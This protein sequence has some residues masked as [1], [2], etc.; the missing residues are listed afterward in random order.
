MTQPEDNALPDRTVWLKEAQESFDAR[1]WAKALE[2]LSKANECGK[3]NSGELEWL[4]DCARWSGRTDLVVDPLEQA[5]RIYASSK[6]CYGAART[7]LGLCHAY[8]DACQEDLAAAWWQRASELLEGLE[9][10]TIHGLH[11]WFLSRRFAGQGNQEGQEREARRALEI[12]RRQGDRNVEALA[13]IEIAH[14]ATVRGR[15]SVVSDALTRATSLAIAG[16]IGLME[17]GMVFCSAIWA[18]RS[19]G[20][21]ERA[22]QWTD[23][24]NRWVDRTRV[25]YFPGLC[26]VHRSEVLRI[27]GKLPQAEH[28]ALEAT[29]MLEA[30][31]PRWTCLAWGEVGEVRRRRGDFE[32]AMHAFRRAL[33][34][35]W[36]P[37]PGMALLTLA[38]GDPQSAFASIE[39][40]FRQ[41][42]PT[43]IC[44]DRANLLQARVTIAIANEAH[45]S[46][47]EAVAELTRLAEGEATPWDNAA[48]HHS[49][50]EFHLG[51]GNPGNA[52]E[53]LIR[54]RND[55]AELSAPFELALCRALLAEA[56]ES[57]GDRKGG[58]S[59]RTAA[60]EILQRIGAVPHT[61]EPPAAPPSRTDPSGPRLVDEGDYWSF[62]FEGQTLR[63]KDSRGIRYLATLLAEPETE[64]LAL[65]LACNHAAQ[66][67]RVDRGDSGEIID[68]QA[69]ASYRGRVRELEE[70]LEEARS[71]NDLGRQESLSMEMEEIS[72][73]LAAAVG[74]GGRSR[75]SGSAAERARQSV[76][77]ALRGL[78]QKIL[79]QNPR[80]GRH[81]EFSVRTGTSCSYRPES[82]PP[83]IWSVD[84][85]SS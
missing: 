51:Q 17:S 69:L 80:L 67:A 83:V 52:V 28:E 60:R 6:D 53:D 42:S 36:D 7:A 61:P 27:R 20:E 44:E 5:Y 40:V 48:L 26:R 3:L 24:A 35:G 50:G 4:A 82:N 54:A 39:R 38:Q 72:R 57:E 59:E 30:S 77:K 13:L 15:T 9:E 63:L 22:Q 47:E 68:S 76:T 32:G 75:K 58:E 85:H 46:A 29:R 25:S 12:A 62:H 19:R 31:I 55:W 45:G 81:L 70:E 37:Q 65:V 41:P 71:G 14:V 18:S 2:V 73:Q 66:G 79:D 1:D 74:L 34:L 21:W 10:S 8:A 84:R 56:L 43:L 49:R 64:H 33:E 23:S 11:A 78:Q 16:E